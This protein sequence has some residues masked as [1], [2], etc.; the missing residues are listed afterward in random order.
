M[1]V[2]S[3]KEVTEL[4]QRWSSGDREAIELTPVIYGELHRIARRTVWPTTLLI[5]ESEG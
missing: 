4:L 2:E 5:L 1:N 3:S